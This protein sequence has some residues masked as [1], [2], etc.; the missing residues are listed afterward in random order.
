MLVLVLDRLGFCATTKAD[1]A[2]MILFAQCHGGIQ[3]LEDEDEQE[4]EHGFSIRNLG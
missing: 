2:A 3:L 4:H 1:F